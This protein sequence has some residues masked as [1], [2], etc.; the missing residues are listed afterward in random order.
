M[1]R[2]SRA[3]AERHR[4]QVVAAASRLVREHGADQ[5]SVP[6]VMAAAGLTHG[7]FYRHFASKDD[8]VAQAATAA[9]AERRAALDALAEQDTPA[10]E[11]AEAE[12]PGPS[13]WAAFLAGYLSA[14]HRD[15]PGLGCAAVALAADAGRARPGDPLHTAYA[16]GLRELAAGV[17]GLARTPGGEG[18]DEN[19]ALAELSTL[20]GAL[21]LSRASA[22]EEISERILSAVLDR[23]TRE[24]G[25]GD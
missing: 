1:P 15:N 4:E 11:G 12:P 5:V 18:V 7:G 25:T 10:R 20:V 24:E 14:P 2:A 16:E 6:Q 21:V 13:P 17:A 8:L 3:D 9:F 23:L 22:G 19:R